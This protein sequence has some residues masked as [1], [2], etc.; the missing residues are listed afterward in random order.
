MA[1]RQPERSIPQHLKLDLEERNIPRL[2]VRKRTISTEQEP[3]PPKLVPIFACSAQQIPT[4][5]NLGLL[6]SSHY[7]FFQVAPQL[8]SQG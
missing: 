6:D 8:S 3:W 2:L 7:Y 5:V 4:A 1:I